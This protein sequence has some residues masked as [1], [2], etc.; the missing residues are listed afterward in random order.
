MEYEDGKD[1]LCLH[2][3]FS[4]NTIGGFYAQTVQ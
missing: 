3:V 2:A 4:T 1:L